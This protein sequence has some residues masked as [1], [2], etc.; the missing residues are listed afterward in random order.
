M[1]QRGYGQF[2]PV[3]KAAE[4]VTERWTPLVLRELLM[5]SRRFNDLRRGVPLMS[6]SLLSQR[7]KALERAGVITRRTDGAHPAYQLT[8]A[9]HELRPIIEM[10]GVWGQRWVRTGVGTADTDLDASLL[11]WDM[12]RGIEA[13]TLPN[14]VVVRF[15]FPD[16]GPG[17]KAWWLVIDGAVDLCLTDPGY[18]VD[19]R[20]RTDVRTMTA[21]WM[22]DIAFGEAVRTGALTLEGP[23]TLQRQFPGWLKLSVFANVPRDRRPAAHRE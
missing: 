13:P 18:H 22:G 6:P 19:L 23:R 12:R 14:R 16:A 4:I 10:L 15:D 11:M 21:V 17:K 8:P 1:G 20:V 9:G 7:L 2:C 5:G 3:A